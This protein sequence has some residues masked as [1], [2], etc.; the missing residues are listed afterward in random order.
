MVEAVRRRRFEAE[1]CVERRVAVEDHEVVSYRGTGSQ[2]VPNEGAADALALSVG[3][4]RDGC[5][6]ERRVGSRHR[7]LGEQHV[8]DD[9]LAV[10]GDDGQVGHERLAL[11]QGRDEFGLVV[12]RERGAVDRFD[13]GPVGGRLGTELTHDCSDG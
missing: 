8:A 13:C 11:T 2:P 9:P 1:P 10:L 4:N 3:M 5:E 6:R 7:D 12:G